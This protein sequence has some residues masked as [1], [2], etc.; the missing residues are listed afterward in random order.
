MVIFREIDLNAKKLFPIYFFYSKGLGLKELNSGNIERMRLSQLRT[1]LINLISG[2][3]QVEN[4]A[5][6]IQMLLGKYRE[7]IL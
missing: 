1:Q 2:A 6:N 7:N 3:L 4:D 5:T